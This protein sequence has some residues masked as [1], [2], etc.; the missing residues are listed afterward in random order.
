MWSCLTTA[1]K[2]KGTG[3]NCNFN[4]Q[5]QDKQQIDLQKRYPKLAG[6]APPYEIASAPAEVAEKAAEATAD[7]AHALNLHKTQT[8]I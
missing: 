1:T 6:Q 2:P 8:R 7:A 5:E 3:A 4:A